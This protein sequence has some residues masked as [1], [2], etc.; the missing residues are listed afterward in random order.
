MESTI[1]TTMK[2]CILTCLMAV[3]PLMSCGHVEHIEQQKDI[4]GMLKA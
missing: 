3:A 2:C 1:Q 4:Q